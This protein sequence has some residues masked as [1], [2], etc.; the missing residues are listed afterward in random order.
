MLL[1]LGVIAGLLLL[2]TGILVAAGLHD[3]MG[4]ADAALV[5]GSKVERDGTPSPRLRA[6]L[7]ETLELYRAGYFPTIIA[8]GGVGKEG[9]DE[10]AVM[11]DYLVAHGVPKDHIIV[12]SNGMTTFASARN[13]LQ[14]ARERKFGS[15]FV[16]SQYFHI[17]RT[18]LALSRFGIS[19]IY[20]AH[21]PYFEIRDFYSSPRELFGY[22][23]YFFRSYSA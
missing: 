9:Y 6:R 5:L 15:V 4:K 22:L 12:D 10:A 2:E 19:T 13:T 11:R 21:A 7:D 14:I 16:I 20:S 23:S 3:E 18:R 8:S 1:A 17:P